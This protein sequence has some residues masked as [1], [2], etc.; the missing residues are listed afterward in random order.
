MA[1]RKKRFGT[2]LAI[3]AVLLVAGVAY[4]VATTGGSARTATAY[5][6]HVG[7]SCRY[8][9][10]RDLDS[11]ETDRLAGMELVGLSEDDE[12]KSV[13]ARFPMLASDTATY[14]EGYGCVLET[15]SE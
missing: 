14:R 2:A 8:I 4:V 9:A 12:A 13:T 10:G 6:A 5:M 1:T 11:C 7:C 3:I 15:W